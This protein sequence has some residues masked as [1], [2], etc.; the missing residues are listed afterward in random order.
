MRMVMMAVV[1]M[2]KHH[3]QKGKVGLAMSQTLCFSPPSQISDHANLKFE[4]PARN[5]QLT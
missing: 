2:K 1:V 5:A 4:S 3:E